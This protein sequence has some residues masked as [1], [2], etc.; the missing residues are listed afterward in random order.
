MEVA[1]GFGFDN[2]FLRISKEEA[3]TG[4]WAEEKEPTE[5]GLCYCASDDRMA[6]GPTQLVS[7]QRTEGT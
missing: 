7:R 1:F 5:A 3:S 4:I 2:D 6:Q